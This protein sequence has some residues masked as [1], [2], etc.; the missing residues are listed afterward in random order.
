MIPMPPPQNVKVLSAAVMT[1]PVDYI[2]QSGFW[3]QHESLVPKGPRLQSSFWKK[4]R[5]FIKLIDETHHAKTYEVGWDGYDAPI[6]NDIAVNSG[7]ELL[8][9]L[10]ATE[11]KP[12]SVL[13]S[14]NGGIGISFR[15][16]NGRRAAVEILNDGSA[17]Y[18][19]Y[20]RDLP[21][22]TDAFD[23][24]SPLLPNIFALISESL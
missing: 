11:L 20:G 6:P 16:K 19:V 9:K 21:T 4:E 22:L 3:S 24:T 18:V 17:T 7:I 2:Q 10:K 15:G 23:L 8:N 12:Y 5:D 1:A 14:A 13:P